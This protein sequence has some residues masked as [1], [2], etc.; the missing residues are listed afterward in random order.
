MNIPLFIPLAKER[1]A[2]FRRAVDLFIS[3]YKD[4]ASDGMWRDLF[5]IVGPFA[6]DGTRLT[7]PSQIDLSLVVDTALIWATT[8]PWPSDSDLREALSLI[9]ETLAEWAAAW[10]ALTNVLNTSGASLGCGHWFREVV[11]LAMVKHRQAT[12]SLSESWPLAS[13][14]VETKALAEMKAGNAVG[15]EEAFARIAGTTKTE[16]TD[17]VEQHRKR[18]RTQE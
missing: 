4:R 2:T 16:W 7:E 18:R 6:R 12:R 17:R 14:E 10:M 9:E 13:E 5:T 1:A 3:H 15:L 8:R 11:P